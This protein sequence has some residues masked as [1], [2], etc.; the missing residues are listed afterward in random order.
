MRDFILS[1]GTKVV[2]DANGT[3]LVDYMV[4][5]AGYKTPDQFVN[6]HDKDNIIQ[7]GLGQDILSGFGGHDTL[8]G[9]SGDDLLFGGDG[10]D[11]LVG[12]VPLM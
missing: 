4:L 5:F 3:T 8:Y 7:G 6:N 1:G 11:L 12:D 2:G 9:G 10:H